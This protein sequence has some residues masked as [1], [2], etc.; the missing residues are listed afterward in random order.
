MPENQKAE[1]LLNLSLEATDAERLASPVLRAGTDAAN[2]RWEVIVKFHGDLSRIEGEDVRVEVL[3]AGYGIV[4]LPKRYIEA[5]AALEEIEFV[6]K[7][8][9]LYAD[10]AAGNYASCL[11]DRSVIDRSFQG[12]GIC[13]GIIDSGLSYE[14]PAFRNPDGTTRVL[15]YYDQVQGREYT[16]EELDEILA[17]GTSGGAD[18]PT[19]DR[20][21]HG[22]AVAAI[23]AGNGRENDGSVNINLVGVAPLAS[24]IIVKLDTGANE[25]FPLTTSL[26]RAMDYVVKR[27]LSLQMPL[28]LN[29]SF[30][31]TYGAHDGTA[32]LERFIDNLSEIG[33]TVICV[34]SGN[35][36][37]AGGHAAG[38]INEG[39][40]ERIIEFTIGAYEREFNLQLWL[41]YVDT[42]EV[43]LRGPGGDSFTLDTY[44]QIGSTLRSRLGSTNLLIYAG[45]PKPYSVDQEVFFDFIPG[46]TYVDQ[47]IWQLILRPTKLVSGNYS[48]YMPSSQIKGRDTRFLQPALEQTLTIPSTAERV[49]TVGAYDG[50]YNTYADFSGRGFVTRLSAGNIRQVKPEIAAPGVGIL[51]ENSYGLQRLDGTSYATPFVTGAAAILMESAILS[52]TDP[53]LYGEKMKAQLCRQAKPLLGVTALP[54]DQTGWGGLCVGALNLR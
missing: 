6:E 23:A 17:S 25:S 46:E 13:I 30:G 22:T 53:Y 7:P 52:G 35:E 38:I 42:Y 34:G 48:L 18:G 15:Y 16:K 50:V 4:T 12:Q 29:L 40:E 24:L 54:N 41:N 32:L 5:L 2:E 20:S 36:G 10:D 11:Y 51:A 28:A 45:A 47:G 9:R 44:I 39:E 27:A 1:N 14:M 43:T 49:I 26:M 31:N 3:S 8:K 19:F 37:A 21:G 33:R